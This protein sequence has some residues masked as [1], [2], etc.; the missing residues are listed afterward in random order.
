MNSRNEPAGRGVF[1]RAETD[2]RIVGRR[3]GP[4]F[5]A[6]VRNML[7]LGKIDRRGRIDE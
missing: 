7:T 1:V 2:G 4:L 6:I 3:G 5:G